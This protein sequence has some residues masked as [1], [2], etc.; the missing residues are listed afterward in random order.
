MHAFETVSYVKLRSVL[1]GA[2]RL[3]GGRLAF[4]TFNGDS[5]TTGTFDW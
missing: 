1:V 2:E 4:C 3:L 5:V